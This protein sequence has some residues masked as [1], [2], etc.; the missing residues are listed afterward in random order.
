MPDAVPYPNPTAPEAERTLEE[1]LAEGDAAYDRGD[2]IAAHAAY[3]EAQRLGG[4]DPRVLSRLGLTL[5][6]VA[7]DE[8]KGVAFCDE[9]IRR[10]GEDPD[11][12]WRL[13]LVYLA[14]FRKERAIRELRRGLA[15]D[16]GN[17]RLLSTI[18]SLGIRRRP[19]IPFLRR[20]NPINKI[21]GKIRH[22][23]FSRRGG[24]GA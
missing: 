17:Q 16:P 14:T 13:A 8:L 20:S 9:A 11:A 19:V 22:R 4:S 7:R 15:I 5:T 10:G 23:W 12:L 21:L 1:Y 3:R 24:Q 6:F 18:D 2:R